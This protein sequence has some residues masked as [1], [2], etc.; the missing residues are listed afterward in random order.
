MLPDGSRMHDQKIATADGARWIAWRDVAVRGDGERNEIQSVGRD[1]TDRTN[2]E[3]ALAEA[4]DQAESRQPR[5][6]ALP[7]DGQPRN[8]HAAQR[9]SRHGAIF[10]STPR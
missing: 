9:H 3:H 1:V 2:A 10:C 4:R 5:Q 7:G 8:P 6:V